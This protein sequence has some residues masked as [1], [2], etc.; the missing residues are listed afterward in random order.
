VD[1][2]HGGR[3]DDP[4]HPDALGIPDSNQAA[5]RAKQADLIQ[6][7]WDRMASTADGAGIAVMSNYLWYTD[8]NFDSGLADTFASGG[9][10]RPAYTTWRGLPSFA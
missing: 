5:Q 4:E 9:A 3:R 8:P 6:R 7:A 1:H 10:I 2:A